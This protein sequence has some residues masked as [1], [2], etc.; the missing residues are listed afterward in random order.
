MFFALIYLLLRCMVG[1]IA[2][3]SNERANTEVEL[4]VLRHQLKVLKRQV[5]RHQLRRRDR[6]F[7]AA[8]SRILPRAR[9]SSFLV[10]PQTLLRWHR[11]LVRKKWTFRRRSTGGRPPI[12]DVVQE[13]IAASGSG[14]SSPSSVSGSR[15]PR[16]ARCCVRTGSGL[17]L[18]E[19]GRPGASSFVRKPREC[20]RLTC[21]TAPSEH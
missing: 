15:R 4:V 8:I 3:S 10:S 12:S 7:M 19:T 21:L 5:G 18:G 16:F 2:G 11:E 17:L 20:W 14:V 9:W 13:L 6:V 1:W